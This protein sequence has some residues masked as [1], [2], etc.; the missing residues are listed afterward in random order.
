MI[1]MSILEKLIAMKPP[2]EGGVTVELNGGI[3]TKNGGE[4]M[5]QTEDAINNVLAMRKTLK[6]Q[7]FSE[8]MI[9]LIALTRV[10]EKQVELAKIQL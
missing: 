10:L 6:E 4:N 1:K 3:T 7:R 2:V 5:N 9:E 8:K